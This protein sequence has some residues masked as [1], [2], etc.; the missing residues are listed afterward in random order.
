MK[1]IVFF[2]FSSRRRHTRLQGDWSSDVCSSDLHRVDQHGDGDTRRTTSAESLSPPDRASRLQVLEMRAEQISGEIWDPREIL[3]GLDSPGGELVL[4]EQPSVV[5]DLGVGELEVGSNRPELQLAQW[6]RLEPLGALEI[7]EASIRGL[8]LQPFVDGEDYPVD[9]RG[10]HG[11]YP[12]AERATATPVSEPPE[13]GT[14][15]RNSSMTWSAAT[16]HECRR[17]WAARAAGSQ[18]RA[19]ASRIASRNASSSPGG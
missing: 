19:S 7:V 15:P 3:E 5:G 2:F 8:A 14:S 10:V 13:L 17:A 12:P 6:S 1:I 16:S 9:D 4:V 11:C 18:G